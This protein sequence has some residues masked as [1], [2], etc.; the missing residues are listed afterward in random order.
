MKPSKFEELRKRV[1]LFMPQ[2]NQYVI[3]KEPLAKQRL[4]ILNNLIGLQTAGKVNEDEQSLERI[5][6]LYSVINN[7]IDACIEE[8]DAK[9]LTFEEKYNLI[10]PV[11]ELLGT[12]SAIEV[13]DICSFCNS[14]NSFVLTYDLNLFNDPNSDMVAYIRNLRESL[15]IDK[16]V[17]S[18]MFVLPDSTLE[19]K[20]IS[21]N[22]PG[23]NLE[24][25]MVIGY[26]LACISIDNLTNPPFANFEHIHKMYVFE[27][28]EQ[29]KIKLMYTAC[30][31]DLSGLKELPES[32]TRILTKKLNSIVEPYKQQRITVKY[33]WTCMECH[34]NNEKEFNA[35]EH[36]FLNLTNQS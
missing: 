4:Q 31:S 26:P 22:L 9:K 6:F 20:E 19:P 25:R 30:E 27:T 23:T 7:Y 11:I 29:E 10:L 17:Y 18:L 16:P 3:I 15:D 13:K 24:F 21:F 1:K 28:G 14:E 36:F 8:L 35:I 33:N 2:S 5:K 34:K 32:I 12:M